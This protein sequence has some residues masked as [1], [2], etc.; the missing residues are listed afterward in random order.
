MKIINNQIDTTTS[1]NAKQLFGYAGIFGQALGCD[2]NHCYV[3]VTDSHNQLHYFSVDKE[4]YSDITQR[5]VSLQAVK[6]E[7]LFLWVEV[8]SGSQLINWRLLKS[9]SNLEQLFPI[10]QACYDFEMLYQLINFVE[11]LEVIPLRMFVREVMKD[12]KLMARFVS[13]PASKRHHH[14][15]PGGLLEHSLECVFITKQNVDMLDDITI[16]EKEVA[17][18]AALF[19]DIGKAETLGQDKHTFAGQIIDHEAFTLLVLAKPL[20]EL[21][22]YWSQGADVFQYLVLWKES[23]GHCRFVTGNAIKLADRLSTSASLNRMA[24]KD[25]PEYF[26]FSK[27]VV[28]SKAHYLNRLN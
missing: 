5:Y 13:I 3:S 19:H 7:H 1:S 10:Y 2:Q 22:K 17:T 9:S 14:S 16:N 4:S 26:H 28:G 24:F 6:G 11:T 25:K 20:N 12:S 23:Q 21:K 15:Y 8:D 18:V 27:L